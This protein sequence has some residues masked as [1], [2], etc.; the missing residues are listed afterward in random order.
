MH[1]LLF[2]CSRHSFEVMQSVVVWNPISAINTYPFPPHL[3][4]SAVCVSPEPPPAIAATLPDRRRWEEALD[5]AEAEEETEEDDE[6]EEAEGKGCSNEVQ[7]PGPCADCCCC[8]GRAAAA[9]DA[10]ATAA[11]AAVSLRLAASPPSPLPLQSSRF[12]FRRFCC[13]AAAEERP[14][15]RP[16]YPG[17]A[18]STFCS[19]F[20]RSAATCFDQSLVRPLIEPVFFL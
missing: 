11:A 6:E 4:A 9:A 17:G 2:V 19:S 3:R 12:R 8:W 20:S 7:P 1:I 5:E 15:I 10:A 13:S 18:P 14:R 16:M